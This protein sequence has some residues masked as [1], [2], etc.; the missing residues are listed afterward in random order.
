MLVSVW[1]KIYMLS[2]LDMHSVPV[3]YTRTSLYSGNEN[4]EFANVKI[5][6]KIC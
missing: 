5:K 3:P 4:N 1:V 2:P 6:I